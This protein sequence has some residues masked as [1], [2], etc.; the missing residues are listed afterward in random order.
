MTGEEIDQLIEALQ[1][2]S[3]GRGQTLYDKAA[4]MLL[5]LKG[6]S[7]AAE[8][9]LMEGADSWLLEALTIWKHRAE[10]AEA[11]WKVCAERVDEAEARAE[12]EEKRVRDLEEAL[13]EAIGRYRRQAAALEAQP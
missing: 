4:D 9:A 11:G 6:R 12:A 3:T 2:G 1:H 10:A 7:E 13:A 8:K 5:A